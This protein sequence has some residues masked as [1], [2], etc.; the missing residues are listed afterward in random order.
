MQRPMTRDSP[1]CN[2]ALPSLLLPSSGPN[3]APST[4]PTAPPRRD[5]KDVQR[6]LGIRMCEFGISVTKPNELERS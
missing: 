6:E 1:Q 4:S 3:R 2:L 5:R